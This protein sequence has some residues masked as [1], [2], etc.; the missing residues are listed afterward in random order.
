MSATK[1][2]PD[3][4][5]KRLVASLEADDDLERFAKMTPAEVD[6][7]LARLGV[8]PK[9]VRAK[10]DA[11]AAGLFGGVETSAKKAEAP[12]PPAARPSWVRAHRVA[13]L[14]AAIVIV[15]LAFA[16]AAAVTYYKRQIQR[17]HVEELRPERT[18][19]QA[20]ADALLDEAV[21]ACTRHD[22]KECVDKV[23]QARQLDPSVADD[24]RMQKL[25]QI[26][27]AKA[28]GEPVP[29]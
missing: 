10:G 19:D 8:D 9:A 1:L 27:D 6:A 29:K 12:K 17:E 22:W 13:L 23:A 24:P 28:K 7:E 21:Q 16:A 4:A 5:L 3:E 18:P 20:R 11:F 14:A 2:P 25:T 15:L 26:L